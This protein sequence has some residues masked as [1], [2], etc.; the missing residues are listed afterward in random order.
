M[1]LDIEQYRMVKEVFYECVNLLEIVFYL[2]VLLFI[3]FLVYKW[4][5][6]FYYWVGIKLYDLVVGSN[7]LKSSYVFSKLRVFEYFL[8]FQK[9]KLVGVIVYYDG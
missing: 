1:K 8:M 2:L 7:C 3:M 6:L 9:D 4:W 5:Q